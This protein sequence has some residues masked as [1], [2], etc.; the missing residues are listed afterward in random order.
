MSDTQNYIQENK[1]RFLEEFDVLHGGFTG[2][3]DDIN[4]FIEFIG[5][6]SHLWAIKKRGNTNLY[7]PWDEI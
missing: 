2:L 5:P 4:G 7:S 3:R 6:G 1:E